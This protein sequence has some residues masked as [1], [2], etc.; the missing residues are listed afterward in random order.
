[1]PR[2]CIY[3]FLK[4][5]RGIFPSG[6]FCFGNIKKNLIEGYFEIIIN[7]YVYILN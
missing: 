5:L 3:F 4:L 2:L 1:M 6:Q 7:V